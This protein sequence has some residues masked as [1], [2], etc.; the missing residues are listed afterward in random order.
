MQ[1]SFV[2]NLIFHSYNYNTILHWRVPFF[3]NFNP[4]IALSLLEEIGKF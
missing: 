3:N 4:L 1:Y 2:H